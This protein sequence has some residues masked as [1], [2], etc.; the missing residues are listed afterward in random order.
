[1]N[2]YRLPNNR[3]IARYN[4]MNREW[5]QTDKTGAVTVLLATE[6]ELI[7][8]K[9]RENAARYWHHISAGSPDG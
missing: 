1:M 6:A 5:L 8:E 9:Y 3:V 4:S 2:R 7:I